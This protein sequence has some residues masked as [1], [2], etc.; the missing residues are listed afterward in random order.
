VGFGNDPKYQRRETAIS[1]LPLID[2]TTLSAFMV[3]AIEP[4]IVNGFLTRPVNHFAL[5]FP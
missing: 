1:D 3:A 5:W 2:R 4:T